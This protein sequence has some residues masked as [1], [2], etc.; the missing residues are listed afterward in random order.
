MKVIETYQLFSE[1]TEKL[2]VLLEKMDEEQWNNPTCYPSWKVRDIVAHLIQTSIG[3]LS[4]QRDG[5]S[6]F[7]D[8]GQNVPSF[9]DLSRFIDRSNS[10]W[11]DLFRTVSPR[12]LLDFIRISE[13][14]LADFILTQELHSKA[15]Y[16][17]TW[18]GESESENWFD[19]GRDYTERWHHQQQIREAVGAEALTEKR[20]LAP[21]LQLFMY[22]LPFWYESIHAEEGTS[23]SIEILGDSGGL[24]ILSRE[25][26][27]WI[28][29]K[30]SQESSN[31]ISFTEDTA[32]RFFTRSLP[33]NSFLDKFQFTGDRELFDNF[34]NVRA[35]MI[36]D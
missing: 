36:N 18:A 26:S 14:Q 29:A 5:Y 20:Y 31:R 27:R 7:G 9:E 28:I 33:V 4:I 30:S 12:I 25:G 19:L 24:W 11:S 35:I 22:S 10:N 32:W 16:A 13:K 34:F 6:V 15:L 3:R 17:V 21:V 1:I 8:V 23:M 2:I